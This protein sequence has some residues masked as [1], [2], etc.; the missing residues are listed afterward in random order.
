[1]QKVKYLAL[2]DSYTIGEGVS[3]EERFPSQTVKLL[4]V[5]D[6][7][8]RALT[9]IAVTGWT[10]L[11]LMTA[12]NAQTPGNDFDIVTLLIGVNDQY[13]KLSKDRYKIQFAALLNRAVEFAENRKNRV[14]VLSIP[15]YSVTPFVDTKKKPLVSL[16]VDEFNAIN[17]EI[18]LQSGI[19]YID[20]T[21]SS[22]RAEN[23]HTL[24]AADGLHPSNK[25]YAIWA[26]MLV[27]L[28]KMALAKDP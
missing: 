10:T 18:T 6:I 5:Q 4:K 22:R 24:I 21:S 19:T 2:G 28:I 13:Q 11:D 8:V 17:K 16:E 27:P 20:I 9:Y 3:E 1:M 14:F 15:D 23:D 12:I 25:E 26:G 7:D